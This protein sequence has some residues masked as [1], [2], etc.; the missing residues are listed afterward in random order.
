MRKLPEVEEAKVLMTEAMDWSVFTWLFEKR[1]VREVADRANAALDGL[2]EKVKSRW[3]AEVKAAYRELTKRT[4]RQ[5]GESGKAT[6]CEIE[7]FVKKVEEADDAARRARTDAEDTFDEAERQMNTGLARE[8]CKKALY[9]WELDEK[10]IRRAEAV[11]SSTKA[12]R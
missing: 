1:R 8:G 10:A 3:S 9:Q 6:D 5:P 12:A 11:P 7:L 4:K 2:N